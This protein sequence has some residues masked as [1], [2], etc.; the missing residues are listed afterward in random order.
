[1]RRN[2]LITGASSGLGAEMARQFAA[3]GHDLALTARRTERLEALRAELTA[4]YPQIKVAIHSLD[5][6]DHDQVFKVFR[7]VDAELP[8]DRIVVNAGLGKGAPLGT[9]RFDA[10][11]D[12]ALTNFVG[13]LAQA[14][15]AMELF[16]ARNAGHLV[17]IASISAL[18]GFPKTV[19]TY[20]AT[21]AGLA[22]LGEGLRLELLGKPIKVSTIYPGYIR[23]E[24][25][26]R[27]AHAPFIVD[28]EPGVRAMV[29]AIEAE[30]AKAYVPARPWWPLAQVMRF[31]P[32]P[33]LKRMI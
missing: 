17:L 18:R 29:A 20:A 10:N 7:E 19:T 26:E 22:S 16:R 4:S 23:S 2:I 14:E 3:K 31:A 27:V 9:G 11:R 24:M 12:T 30:K 25:N 13:A 8:L 15:V 28:T 5:V 1:M 33:L 6:T 32:L 21:K